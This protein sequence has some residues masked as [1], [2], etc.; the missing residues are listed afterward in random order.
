MRSG[1]A[2][3]EVRRGEI[4]LADLGAP[5][6]HEQGMVRPVLVLSAQAW[7]DSHPPVVAV[8]PLTRTRRD[9]PTHVEVEPGASGLAATSYVKCE[10]LR[11]ISPERLARRFGTVEDVTLLRV[12]VIT[13]RL[14][15]LS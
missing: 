9:S 12:E 8:V 10:D 3:G 15:G 1:P 14:L 6:G 13:R 11:A 7:L 5:V 4:Y 2:A